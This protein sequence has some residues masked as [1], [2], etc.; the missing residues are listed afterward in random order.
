MKTQICF[1]TNPE[2]AARSSCPRNPA[3][4]SCLH[5][6]KRTWTGVSEIKFLSK[7]TWCCPISAS[8]SSCPPSPPLPLHRSP[9]HCRCHLHHQSQG[10]LGHGTPG[11]K[12]APGA[13]RVV[14]SGL[15]VGAGV[16][17]RVGARVGAD[18][19]AAVGAAVG[20]TEVKTGALT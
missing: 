12:G 13:T 5:R 1:I 2:V 11:K 10:G 17:A 4:F 16:D 18:V 6:T 14:E 15:G 3:Y 7:A 9:P 8:C 19:G 20:A